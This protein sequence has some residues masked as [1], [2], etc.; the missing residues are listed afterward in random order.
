MNDRLFPVWPDLL[1][2]VDVVQVRF[3]LEFVSPC[4]LQPADFLD[5]GRTLRAAGRQSA[6][7]LD[8]AALRRLDGLFLPG[9]SDDP[10]ARRRYQKPA[11]G[12][13][14]SIPVAGTRSLDAG[15]RLDL[16]ILF[17]GTCISSL[18][19][20][21]GSLIQL[22]RQGLIDGQGCFHVTAV[23]SQEAEQTEYP[24]WRQSDPLETLSAVVRPMN[25][26]LHK[27]SIARSITLSFLTPTRLLTDRR[28]IRRP[29][30]VQLF[31]FMLRRVTS[32]LYTYAGVEIGDDPARFLV[33]A[34]SLQEEET[35]FEWCDWRT[36]PGRQAQKLG[37]FVGKMRLAGPA[38]EELYWI[39]ALASLLGIGKS[40][41]YGAGAFS[42][43]S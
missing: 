24:A 19:D 37:G 5:F 41:T 20:F 1:Q 34:G 11:P 25:W 3:V 43:S 4:Q 16:H 42:V 26:L 32:M 27:P 14:V 31:P 30:F 23:Y 36:L 40:A 22:G 9:L 33:L 35:C 8:A 17:I 10:V 2:D 29:S 28:P 6:D 38:M 7:H 13:V 15:D 21:L 39:L 12:F 18:A